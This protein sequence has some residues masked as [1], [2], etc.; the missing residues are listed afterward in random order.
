[1]IIKNK[2][3]KGM[4]ASIFSSVVML[5]KGRWG[6]VGEGGGRSGKEGEGGYS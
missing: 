3:N 5:G 2:K 6:K 1:M 4:V